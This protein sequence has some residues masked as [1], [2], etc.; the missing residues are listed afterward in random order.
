MDGGGKSGSGNAKAHVH[1]SRLSKHR[2]PVDAESCLLPQ[3][4]VD[5]Q[6]LRQTRLR[7]CQYQNLLPGQEALSDL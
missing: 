5:E 4:E 1:P 2:G 7:K 3:T 6:H